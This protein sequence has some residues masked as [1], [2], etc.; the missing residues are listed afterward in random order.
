MTGFSAPAGWNFVMIAAV[1][2]SVRIQEDYGVAVWGRGLLTRNV[3]AAD[4]VFAGKFE[5]EP[6]RIVVDRLDV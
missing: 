2:S 4:L 1:V 6:L 3:Q 5:S